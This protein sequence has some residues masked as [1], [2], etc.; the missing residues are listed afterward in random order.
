MIKLTRAVK[1]Y[2]KL[3]PSPSLVMP[4]SDSSV[5][6]TIDFNGITG[7]DNEQIFLSTSESKQQGGFI[8]QYTTNGSWLPVATRGKIRVWIEGAIVAGNTV[9]L[10][11]K[12]TFKSGVHQFTIRR[13]ANVLQLLSC[14]SDGNPD[15]PTVLQSEIECNFGFTHPQG[16]IIGNR[17]ALPPDRFCD[18]SI[19]RVGQVNVA[20]TDEEIS[21]MAY[22]MTI[23]QLGKTP[24]WYYPLATKDDI[25]DFVAYNN[26]QSSTEPPYGYK[27]GGYGTFEKPFAATSLW[28]S[29][30]VNPVLSSFVIPACYRV[31]AAKTSQNKFYV[32]ITAGNYSSGIFKALPTDAPLT[33][34]KQDNSVSLYD[35]DADEYLPSITIPHWP[36][37][38]IG[39]EGTDGHCDIIDEESKVI[40]SF[41]I[42]KKNT[43]GQFTARQYTWAPLDGSGW[44]TGA[45]Y[46]IG[47]RAAG[48]ATCAGMIRKH[49]ID[50]GK[51]MYEH[52][53]ACSLDYTGLASSPAY[54]SPATSSDWNPQTNS[55]AIPQ[56]ALIM[57]PQSY[58][59]SRL[60]RWPT[61]KK[62]AETLKVYGARVVDRNEN[63]PLTIYV[64]KDAGWKW[65]PSGVWDNALANEL[66]YIR[67]QIRQVA[68]VDGY[69]NALGKP[70][71]TV[72]TGENM[73]S[74]RGPWFVP[75]NG[76]KIV[77]GLFSSIN[78][79]LELP[80]SGGKW[81]NNNCK[82][83]VAE[84]KPVEGKYY[85]LVCETDCGAWF[86]FSINITNP[87]GTTF[88]KPT[89]NFVHGSSLYIKWPKGAWFY[90]ECGKSD[91]VFP[92]Y[93]KWSFVEVGESEYNVSVP[94]F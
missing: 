21:K 89:Q 6:F 3:A 25:G 18:Q 2:L 65:H 80:A 52:A 45:H 4:N 90:V 28:N 81:R 67:E 44:G 92:G 48:V 51:E 17:A 32:D 75:G 34:Y 13:K 46:Y 62:V 77:K 54:C 82:F 73:L 69:T 38:A 87:D 79:R 85:K 59:T 56:G 42:L 14:L 9:N 30:P 50:D 40:H 15:N 88:W 35:K 53:L 64:E 47:S 33:V 55:G 61:V 63:T 5:F 23:K 74:M 29:K 72:M 37:N 76:D 8:V 43:L 60:D 20:L 71:N 19:S 22:G 94:K 66:E 16:I 49:E 7:G 78:Q 24:A 57:L 83:K 93:L 26:P 39:A 36:A 41:W 10:C 31:G 1:Q 27:E 11:S 70:C 84:L 58:D 86:K 91:T 68:S 12:D